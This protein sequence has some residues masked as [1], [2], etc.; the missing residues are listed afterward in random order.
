M[1]LETPSSGQKPS[2]GQLDAHIDH[3]PCARG[4]T[5]WKAGCGKSARPV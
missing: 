4:E 3:P 1:S 5:S 2:E